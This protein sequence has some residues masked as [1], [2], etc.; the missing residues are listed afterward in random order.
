MLSL[1]GP[2]LKKN[3]VLPGISLQ[4]VLVVKPQKRQDIGTLK[5]PKQE[6]IL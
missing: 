5:A 3:T 4:T 2:T 6:P 1:G